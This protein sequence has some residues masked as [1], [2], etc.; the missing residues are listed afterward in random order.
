MHYQG[1]V[2]RPPSEAKSIL[3]QVT[4]GCSHNKCTFCGMY[5]NSRFSIKDDDIIMEDIEY[6]SR[7]FQ[8]Q[9]RLFICDGDALILPQKRLLHILNAI[10]E[11]LPWVERVGI[12][13][14]TKSIRLKSDEDLQKLRDAGLKI[15]YMGLESGDDVTLEHICKGS[16]AQRMVEMGKRLRSAGMLL[17]VTVLLGIA[18]KKRSHVHAVETGRVLSAIDPEYVGALS[19]MLSQGTDLYSSY[20][21]GLFELLEPME[22]LEELAVMITHTDL[23]GGYFHA[24]HAS[25]YLPIKARLPEEKEKT[26]QLI[27]SA[28]QGKVGLKAEQYRSF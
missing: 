18:G 6:A 14:N 5:K 3:L 24:N 9:K 20:E 19:L 27:H 15:A 26:L 12:Y 16:N 23:S 25:N 7:H 21:K 28:L 13:A 10:R 2:F 8:R 4:T 17:S 1:D 22:M 11:Q